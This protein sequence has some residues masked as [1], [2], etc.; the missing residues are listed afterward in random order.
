MEPE[1]TTKYIDWIIDQLQHKDQTWQQQRLDDLTR[2]VQNQ[3]SELCLF[4]LTAD[5]LQ[6][7]YAQQHCRH[8]ETL[9]QLVQDSFVHNNKMDRLHRQQ[10]LNKQKLQHLESQLH[11]WR[12][13]AA[14]RRNKKAMREK[15]YHQ[16]YFVPVINAQYKKKY[17]RARDKNSAVEQHVSDLHRV[18]DG[19]KARVRQE[20]QQWAAGLHQRQVLED[21][22]HTVKAALERLDQLMKDL[23]DTRNFWFQFKAHH[24]ER[25]LALCQGGIDVEQWPRSATMD[26]EQHYQ[27][28]R[29]WRTWKEITFECTH[30]HATIEGWPHLDTSAQLTCLPCMKPVD[31]LLSPIPCIT[32]HRHNPRP[33]LPSIPSILSSTLPY[34]K[35]LKSALNTKIDFLANNSLLVSRHFYRSILT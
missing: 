28:G 7:Q 22:Q 20:Q 30:C 24:V 9:T 5:A 26:Y 21:Q 25:Y 34:V 23:A 11:H 13:D 14:E 16:V 6:S 31:P 33:R 32:S 18:M 35:K 12:T 2:L 29:Q 19:V 15:Q 3:Q 1:V 27:N 4:L 17:M 8:G 10:Q